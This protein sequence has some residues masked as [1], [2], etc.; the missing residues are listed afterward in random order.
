MKTQRC[1]VA[2]AIGCL[3]SLAIIALKKILFI[4]LQISKYLYF[5]QELDINN[6]SGEDSHEIYKELTMKVQFLIDF[7]HLRM[8]NHTREDVIYK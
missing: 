4:H 8:S 2:E 5:S 7:H 3:L 1:F 6:G